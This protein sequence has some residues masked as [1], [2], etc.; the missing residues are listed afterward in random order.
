MMAIEL[1]NCK[2]FK[3]WLGTTEIARISGRLVVASAKYTR[4]PDS[5]LVAPK[6]P[7]IAHTEP[8]YEESEFAVC[9]VRQVDAFSKRCVKLTHFAGG[10]L[11]QSARF[12]VCG[13]LFV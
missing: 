13:L 1:A 4:R 6:Q 11:G 8:R 5:G 12:V 9:A 7:A 2:Y 3:A 10:E